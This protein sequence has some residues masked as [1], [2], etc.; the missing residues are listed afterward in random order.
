MSVTVPQH[1]VQQFR[2][3]VMLLAQQRGSKLRGTVREESMT[4]VKGF[5]DRIGPTTVTEKLTRH[6]DT[7]QIDT[8]SSRRAITLRDFGWA[9]LVDN[10]DQLRMLLDPKSAMTRN[11]VMAMGRQ[12]DDLIIAAFN[13]TAEEGQFGGTTVTF[14]AAQQILHGSTGLTVDKV[15]QTLRT[16]EENDVDTSELFWVISPIAKEDLLGNTEVTSS[17]FVTDKPL[18][19]GRIGFWMGFNWIVSSRLPVASNIR[20]TFAYSMDGMGLKVG[21]DITTRV[22]TRHDKWDAAEILLTMSFGAT[23]IEDVQVME[24]QVDETA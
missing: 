20:S 9:D 8:Q 6:D 22:A 16:F 21:K 11:A 24:I 4:G 2:D 23:R 13:G 7:P 5:F 12:I 19:N 1:Y 14:P 18:V 10:E 15:K 3:N 17:D